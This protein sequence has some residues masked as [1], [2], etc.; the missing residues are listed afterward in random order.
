MNPNFDRTRKFPEKLYDAACDEASDFIRWS[1]TGK[2]IV[3]NEKKFEKR[4]QNKFISEK[5]NGT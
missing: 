4:A 2:A 1:A 3:V 5:I